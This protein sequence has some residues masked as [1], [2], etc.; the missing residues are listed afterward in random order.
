MPRRP[1]RFLPVVLIA[2]AIQ[3]LAQ[4]G[5]CWASALAVADPLAAF[6]ICHSSAGPAPAG[7]DQGDH[8]GHDGSCDL[9]CVVHASTSIDTPQAVMS[10]MPLHRE[11]EAVLRGY[12]FRGL[13]AARIGSNSLARGPPQAI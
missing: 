12:E 4:I 5:A 9:C 8:S 1:Q 7:P 6:P 2:L 11:V 13:P 3:M 10:V